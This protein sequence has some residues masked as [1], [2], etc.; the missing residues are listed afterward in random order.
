MTTAKGGRGDKLQ[1]LNPS[2]Y[3][4]EDAVAEWLE[5]STFYL[6][7][8]SRHSRVR[9]TGRRVVPSGKELTQGNSS[10]YVKSRLRVLYLK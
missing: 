8:N 2:N 9:D 10:V 4:I 6:S 3:S 7:R 5:L 1:D